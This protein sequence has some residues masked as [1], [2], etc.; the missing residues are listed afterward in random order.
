[1]ASQQ[2]QTA[3]YDNT[4]AVVGPAGLAINTFPPVK[5]CLLYLQPGRPQINKPLRR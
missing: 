1:M 5:K 4:A 2:P 3:S